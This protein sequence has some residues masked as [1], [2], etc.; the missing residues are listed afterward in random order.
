MTTTRGGWYGP[1]G[2][3]KDDLL[4]G[5]PMRRILTAALA[6]LALLSFPQQSSASGLT[7][8]DGP[9]EDATLPPP[10]R[11]TIWTF[12]TQARSQPIGLMF[13]NRFVSRHTYEGD[14]G[15]LYSGTYRQV[16]IDANLSPAFLELGP[17]L[18]WKPIN[19]FVY[20]VGYNALYFWGILDYP[21]SFDSRRSP[22]GD[23]V[24][25]ARDADDDDTND[26]G[27]GL[28][29]RLYLAQTAQ[30]QVGKI[31]V[32]N[33][34]TGFLHF[35]P[36]FD[37]PYVRERMYDRLL[38]TDGDLMVVN[39]AAVLYEAWNGPGDARLLVGGFHEFVWSQQQR[40]NRHRAGM[41]LAA[42][43]KHRVGNLRR[44]RVYLQTGVNVEDPNR[45]GAIFAQGGFGF[46]MP[47]GAGGDE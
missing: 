35:F 47:F 40:A 43:P 34:L 38:D 14:G 17:S 45:E 16:G 33:K 21:L 27:T 23:N 7:G 19:L 41:V 44:F 22:Y 15:V 10:V 9:S 42:F 24:I 6:A 46:D 31:I 18:E 26:E 2:T 11:E 1:A 3:T 37:G 32:Q 12:D 20:S 5:I 39:L 36:G 29:H 28:A 25:D 4:T 13:S 8:I 30:L